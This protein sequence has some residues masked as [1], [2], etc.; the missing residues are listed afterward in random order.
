MFFENF[1]IFTDFRIMIASCC[2]CSESVITPKKHQ[3]H[4]LNRTQRHPEVGTTAFSLGV[5][6]TRCRV[7][8]TRAYV[9]SLVCRDRH[10]HFK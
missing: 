7:L 8:A 9:M 5:R 4:G 10:A 1:S 2:P 6:K 3:L